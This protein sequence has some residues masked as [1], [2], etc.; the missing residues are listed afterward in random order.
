[1]LS[2]ILFSLFIADLEEFLVKRGIR[3]VAIS[4]SVD[5]LTLAYA[6]DLVILVE[7]ISGMM[8]V[9]KVLRVLRCKQ[10]GN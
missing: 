2:P 1:M 10:L 3:G 7:N 9:L 6:D 8:R 5:V 4:H